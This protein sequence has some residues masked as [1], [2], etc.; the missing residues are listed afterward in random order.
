MTKA[1]LITAG[2]RPN[3]IFNNQSLQLGDNRYYYP[4]SAWNNGR[5][6]QTWWQLTKPFLWP[7]VRNNR[8]GLVQAEIRLREDQLESSRID[9]IIT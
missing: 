5:N 6:R 2:L 9:T 8:I 7:G 3:P 1:D 4:G